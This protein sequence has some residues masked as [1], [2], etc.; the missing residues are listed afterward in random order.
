MKT[1]N[2]SL[3]EFRFYL[4]F[5]IILLVGMYLRLDQF[6]LQVLIDDEWHAVH[7][8]LQKTPKE[9]F[10]SLGHAD[11]SIPLALLYYWELTYFGLSELSMRWPM[12]LAGI[13]ILFV[14]P[15]YL[16]RFFSDHLVL[17]FA[18]FLAISP[19]LIIYSRT[20]RPY[21]LTLL[22]SLVAVAA[23]YSFI[24]TDRRSWKLAALY[25][26]TASL[27]A[28]L[29]LLSLP[30]VLAPFLTLGLPAIY[31]RDWVRVARMFWLG[32]FTGALLL[33]LLLPPLLAHPEALEA[34]LGIHSIDFQTLYGAL[35]LWFGTSSSMVVLVGILLAGIGLTPL[36][37]NLPILPAIL[38]GVF[39]TTGIILF[40][41]PAWVKHPLTFAR[42]LLI[43]LPLLLLALALGIIR[44]SAW[45]KQFAGSFSK[46]VLVLVWLLGGGLLMV[47]SPLKKLLVMPNSNSLHLLYQLDFRPDQNP[48]AQYQENIPVSAFWGKF[49]S[50]PADSIKIAAA[51]FYFESYNW[52]AARWEQVSKQRVMPAYLLGLCAYDRWGEVPN[53]DGYHFKNVGYA[54]D[55]S[56]LRDRGF[57]F[58]VFQKNFT[59]QTEQ[60][61]VS[62]GEKTIE[63][64]QKL[65]DNFPQ[66]SYE[67]K[68]LIAFPLSP[69]ATVIDNVKR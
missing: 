6:N 11:Y 50:L 51:P 12:M 19:L 36:W 34:K 40:T 66:P 21:S 20:A 38:L 57:D 8:L 63:C 18:A 23:F 4:I 37:R 25:T 56:D 47:S 65:R 14:L 33:V 39:I 16:R 26:L 32:L 62:L 2:S 30:L 59:F 46:P 1:F 60:G 10:L 53:S 15:L 49:S 55:I 13:A 42:Y 52:D 7:Q 29:H 3:Y 27:S 28:W 67:D 35:F 45:F 22:L 68:L 24:A 64:E 54:A 44:V 48:I 58:L 31:Q 43:L 5:A 69:R 41:Q 61:Q 17:V 9:L